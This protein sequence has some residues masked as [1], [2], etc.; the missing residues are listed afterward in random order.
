MAINCA[1]DCKDGCVLGNDCPNLKYTAEATKFISDTPLDK[2]LEMADDAVRRRMT[3][4]ASRPPKW[5]L[6][7]D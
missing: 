5:I 6:P 7:E 3:E 1:V 4:R 2:M